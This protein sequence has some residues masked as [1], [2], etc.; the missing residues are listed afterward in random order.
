MKNLIIYLIVVTSLT[1]VSCARYHPTE[2]FSEYSTY[3][4]KEAKKGGDYS[5]VIEYR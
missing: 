4:I 1:L 3:D 5:F 2:S